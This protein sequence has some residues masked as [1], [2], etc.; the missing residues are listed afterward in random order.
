[1]TIEQVT[2]LFPERTFALVRIGRGESNSRKLV[3]MAQWYVGY[4]TSDSDRRVY[5]DGGERQEFFGETP[6]EA[7]ENMVRE[8]LDSKKRNVARREKD[9]EE[10]RAEA[11]EM[12]ERFEK[13]L[14]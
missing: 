5:H 10:A 7:L 14:G 12:A 11:R 2:K 3:W 13:A 6:E 4:Y 9:L 8:E 1:M